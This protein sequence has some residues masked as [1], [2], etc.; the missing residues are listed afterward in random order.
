MGVSP[1]KYI[2]YLRMQKAV[3]LLKRK[4][5]SIS[6]IA[7]ALGYKNQFY[8]SKEFKNTL[9]I[10]HLNMGFNL[11]LLNL[12]FLYYQRMRNQSR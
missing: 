2:I 7:Y 8:F 1:M 9:D 4:T 3:E 10:P 12:F 11:F 6:Q 5:F